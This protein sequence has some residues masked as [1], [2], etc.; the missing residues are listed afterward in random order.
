MIDQK[1]C[2]S[3]TWTVNLLNAF[4]CLE[5]I[6]NFNKIDHILEDLP[7]QEDALKFGL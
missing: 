1:V 2:N 3:L 6:S 7:I 5:S 4:I